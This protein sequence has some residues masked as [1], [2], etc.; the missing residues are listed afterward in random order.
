[1]RPKRLLLLP[2]LVLV[3]VLVAE[4]GLQIAAFFVQRATR[5]EM[6]VA[7]VTGNVRV[8]CLGDSH[9]YGL[10]VE[11]SEAYPQ[12]LESIWNQR[13][14][15]PKLEVLN[16]GV[17][18]TS[19]SRLVRELPRMLE[20][21]DPDTL[22]VMVGGNDFW[23]L[24]V[25][26]G[27]APATG[28]GESFLKRHS[29]LYRLYY[30]FRRG[31]Q[32]TAPE[33]VL[34]P[35]ATLTGGGDYRIRAGD[36]EFEMGYTAGESA[37][38]GEDIAG[39]RRNLR[40]IIRLARDAKRPLYLMNYPTKQN[41]YLTASMVIG[42]VAVETGTPLIDLTAEFARICPKRDCPETVFQDGHPKAA[43][44]RIVAETIAERLA[45]RG[46]S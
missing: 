2:A 44:Y 42:D 16:V 33:I 11:R 38:I 37:D 41:P 22:I 23:T 10:W 30:L 17:P 35:N 36:R 20:T 3:Y 14:L 13:T 1:M 43:G 39:L 19:S 8:L 15:S 6:P 7:W 18:G 21:F 45:R 24:P 46:A 12:Q 28:P 31:R 5:A 4:A 40:R 26:L 34:D 27:D 25:P 9:T 29:L 32:M